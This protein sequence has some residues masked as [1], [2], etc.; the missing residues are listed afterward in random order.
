MGVKFSI[1]LK[2]RVFIMGIFFSLFV[3]HLSFFWCLGKA[4]LHDCGILVIQSQ[5]LST[6]PTRPDTA[7][8]PRLHL[9]PANRST[10]ADTQADTQTDLSSLGAYMRL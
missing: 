10:C 7:F 1:Y 3:P 4:V 5:S 9:H 6:F 8:P 2:R